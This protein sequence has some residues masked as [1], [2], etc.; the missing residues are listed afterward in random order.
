LVLLTSTLGAFAC[1]RSES[2][3]PVATKAPAAMLTAF[4]VPETSPAAPPAVPVTPNPSV[5]AF[6]ATVDL[7][8]FSDVADWEWNLEDEAESQDFE[9]DADATSFF[10]PQG[11]VVTYK[12]KAL[13][14]TP[15]FTF[16]WDFGDGSPKQKGEM[17]KHIFTALGSHDVLCVG[18]DASG[19]DYTVTLTAMIITQSDWDVRTI[20]EPREKEHA[21]AGQAPA[22]APSAAPPLTP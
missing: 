22:A 4:S 15:P 8:D 14:G 17:V 20:F 12:A 6:M 2:P 3:A 9:I 19:A 10:M 21:G 7:N 13:N 18:R 5:S 16:E 11:N 1:S